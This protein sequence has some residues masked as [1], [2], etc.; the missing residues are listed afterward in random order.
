MKS[1]VIGYGSIGQR[2]VRVL[3]EM[4][5]SVSVLSRRDIEFKNIYSSLEN[6]LNNNDFDYIIIA[7]ET[8]SHINTLK[9]LKQLNFPGK[10]LVEKPLFMH[11]EEIHF[12]YSHIY[13]A[14]NLRFHPLIEELKGQLS[15]EKVLSV[16][17]Y[18]GQYLPNWRQNTDYTLS[19]SASREKGGG[20][21]RD[22]S[23]ELDYLIMLFGEWK[24]L[25]SDVIKISDLNIQTEDY[26]N[27]HY[28]TKSNSRVT[29]E[30]NYLDR[31]TQRYVIVKTNSRTIKV[32]FIHN[33]M[34]CNGVIKQFAPLDRD[35]TYVKQHESVLNGQLQCCSFTE[36]LKVI[37]MIEA[38]ENSSE[39]KGWVYND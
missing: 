32:D 30:L 38:V 13:V 35:Y 33:T 9:Q 11:K 19:Y 26:V 16:N 20:V 3:T 34:N 4:G 8:V 24:T 6:A 37:D 23:H 5:V 10:I 39:I 31:I 14:Y 1:L 12:D 17:A 18:V 15:N 7:N 29:V 27:I 21:L 28:V 36:G 2:H 22:L 25:V